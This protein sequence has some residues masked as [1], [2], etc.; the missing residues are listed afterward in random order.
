MDQFQTKRLQFHEEL[1]KLS[2]AAKP[3]LY[4]NPPANVRLTYPAVV[5]SF[6]GTNDTFSDGVRYLQFHIY[7]AVVIT[8]DP[9]SEL[10]FLVL[11]GFNYSRMGTPYVKDNLYHTP[12]TINYI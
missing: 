5:Y 3:T 10:P 6:R 4:F 12:I 8:T 1:A 11:N 9:D 2:P 7:E